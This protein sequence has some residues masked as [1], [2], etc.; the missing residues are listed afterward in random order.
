MERVTRSR[1]TCALCSKTFEAGTPPLPSPIWLPQRGLY[2]PIIESTYKRHGYYCRSR[3]ATKKASRK[4]ACIA[5]T[6]AKTRCDS[7]RPSCSRCVVK[8]VLCQYT[9]DRMQDS[10]TH[11]SLIA[12]RTRDGSLCNDP[13]NPLKGAGSR[14][15]LN[16][17][18]VHDICGTKMIEKTLP[19]LEAMPYTFDWGFDSST[20]NASCSFLDANFE[21]P[22]ISQPL[23][24]PNPF[25]E[26]VFLSIPTSMSNGHA[27]RSLTPRALG[28]AGA[29][30]GALFLKRILSSYPRMM[31]RKETL[32]PF[33][34]PVWFLEGNETERSFPESLVNCMTIAQMFID[35]RK[36]TNKFL[37]RTI[38]MEQERF[39][40]EVW[41]TSSSL[42]MIEPANSS[43]SIPI[44]IIG[45][46]L[47]PHKL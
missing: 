35:R 9:D 14:V 38:R 15:E 34:H 1:L 36:E 8:R 6:E 39:W 46:F 7:V 21:L 25:T 37:W 24:C 4:R 11:Q 40:H 44:T 26:N 3:Q 20:G 47:L 10:H 18:Q 42:R 19:S 45:G 32:P 23:D 13:S 33:I 43:L 22:N 12:T 41:Y 27:S 30:F 28:K 2:S 17:E 5:C 29:K 16:Y 31:V